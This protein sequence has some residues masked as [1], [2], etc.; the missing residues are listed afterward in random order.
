MPTMSDHDALLLAVLDSPD[1]DAPR[2][3][4]A[5][6]L[7]EAGEDDRAAFIR[8][9]IELAKT[10][11]WE[12]FAV[13][14]RRRPIE[15]QAGDR[16]RP[17]L[18]WAD[19]WNPSRPFRRGLGYAVK[20]GQIWQLLEAGERL[21]ASAPIGELHLPGGSMQEFQDLV[22]QPWLPLV[23]SIRFWGL[24]SPNFPV[25]ALGASPL[26]TG[27][28][29]IYFEKASS[30]GMSFLVEGLFQSPLGRQLREL[31]FRVGDGAQIDLVE[32]FESGGE[33]F[34]DRLTFDNMGF[35]AEAAE[36]LGRS[37][38][39][40]TLR[41]LEFASMY[42]ADAHLDAL[43]GAR[44]RKTERLAFRDVG[45]RSNN[46]DALLP[47]A[48]R[49]RFPQLRQLDF[50]KSH[51]FREQIPSL[52]R[53]LKVGLRSLR[54]GSIRLGEGTVGAVVDSA[55]WPFLVELDLSH[56]DLD[57][58]A[59][60]ALLAAIPPKELVTL[61]LRGNDAISPTK[62]ADLQRRYGEAIL[63]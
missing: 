49:V 12:P 44:L 9:Q 3:V 29:S 46:P 39:L 61:D 31:T 5:D 48:N 43:L 32:A 13:R 54:L 21:F 25:L 33:T 50:T 17:T 38:A 34:L 4:F 1:E 58:G 27:L 23:Q 10:P 16:W 7:Q 19:Y 36:R 59:A 57:D 22:R 15:E 20:V 18:P 11:E 47:L 45:F 42:F 55:F 6:F 41:S 28:R 8:D 24:S 53:K 35:E 51:G 56:N 2:L 37:P 40:A 26:A 14:W 63:L 52:V 30:P 62:R 60:R